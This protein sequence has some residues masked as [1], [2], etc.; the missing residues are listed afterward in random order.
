MPNPTFVTFLSDRWTDP[1]P[2]AANDP[3]ALNAIGR[4]RKFDT[5]EMGFIVSDEHG[6]YGIAIE[7]EFDWHNSH[8]PYG[9]SEAWWKDL[10]ER[11]AFDAVDAWG[12]A[13]AA[14]FPVR[15]ATVDNDTFAGRL[16]AHFFFAE[17]D[18]NADTLSAFLRRVNT[19]SFPLTP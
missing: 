8:E 3:D 11:E 5:D 12:R 16:A 7:W 15:T 4:L 1:L 13:V 9:D 10:T 2:I 6:T 17:A 18:L 14:K 19:T